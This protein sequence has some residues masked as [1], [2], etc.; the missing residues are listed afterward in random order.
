MLLKNALDLRNLLRESKVIMAY[1]GSVS[2][3]LMLTLADMLKARLI[4]Q[5]DSKRSKL[6]F[7]CSCKVFKN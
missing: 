6:F 3:E 7:L 2:D 1:N 5:D 4:A